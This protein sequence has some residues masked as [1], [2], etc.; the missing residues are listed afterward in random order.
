MTFHTCPIVCVGHFTPAGKPSPTVSVGHYT[1]AR[2]PGPTVPAGYLTQARKPGSFTH[3]EKPGQ[4]N[5]SCWT[6]HTRP[7]MP[8]PAVPNEHHEHF[9]HT[10]M[11]GPTLPNKHITGWDAWPNCSNE[12]FT[13]AGMPGPNVPNEQFTHT[14]G[15]LAQLFPMSSSLTHWGAWPDRFQ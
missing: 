5:C 12:H 15:C 11:T 4:P 1:S 8:G 6:F 9:T 3:V 7:G 13:Q 10:G 14:L 2:K